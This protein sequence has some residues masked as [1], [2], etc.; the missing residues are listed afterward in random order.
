[1]RFT[2]TEIGAL[3]RLVNDKPN[4]RQ[5]ILSLYLTKIARLCGYLARASDPP[6]GTT[7]TWRGLSR[8]TDI[9]LDAVIGG[10]FVGN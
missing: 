3:D 5:E 7:I 9:A 6:P 8:L 10:Q 4:A 1:M 2:A